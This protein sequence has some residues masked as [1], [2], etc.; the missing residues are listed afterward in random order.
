MQN[1]T[2]KGGENKVFSILMR[3]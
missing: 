1:K 3:L 2:I